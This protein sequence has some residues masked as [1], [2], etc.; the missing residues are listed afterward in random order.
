M[1][2]PES[3]SNNSVWTSKKMRLEP[4]DLQILM[5]CRKSCRGVRCKNKA[6]C[7]QDKKTCRRFCRCSRACPKIYRP[8][9]GS[10]G[11]TYANQ[12]LLNYATCQSKGKITKKRNGRCPCKKTCRNV[13]CANG[14]RCFHNPRTCK[15]KCACS[16]A[17][18]KI[19]KPV[20]GTDGV[21]YDNDCLL[22]YATCKSKGKIQKK[23]DGKCCSVDC[24]TAKCSKGA[25]CF[26]D[27]LKCV[28]KCVCS[29]ACPKILKPVCGTDGVTYDNEC[30][31][32]YQF[33][34][35]KGKVDK[36]S[37]GKCPVCPYHNPCSRIRC[38]Y[39]YRCVPNFSRCA[40][41]CQ[42]KVCPNR[43]CVQ[44]ACDAKPCKKG[45]RCIEICKNS[46]VHACEISR[47]T[48]GG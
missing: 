9:C 41:S 48:Y 31:L 40:Y 42:P 17:C 13:R 43:Q 29:K 45:Q 24:T 35:T 32:N 20:C 12:C 30:L 4:E 27:P 34:K 25:R 28:T 19:L 8:V 2:L 26:H 5:S 11:V 33:C 7:F 37:D 36:K 1:S 47:Y 15:T 21:T 23:K 18:P 38:R 10:N 46:C 6:R 16:K 3:L 39:G 22:R 44:A 14:A